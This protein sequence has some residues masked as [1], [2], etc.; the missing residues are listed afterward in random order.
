MNHSRV[1]H[2]SQ[3][4]MKAGYRAGLTG[5]PKPAR[6]KGR[7]FFHGWQQGTADRAEQQTINQGDK[8]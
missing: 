6:E 1:V 4:E 8:K 5:E 7:A 2:Q 3:Q